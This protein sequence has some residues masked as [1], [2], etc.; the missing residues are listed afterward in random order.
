MTV[1]CVALVLTGALIASEEPADPAGD[2]PDSLQEHE[3]FALKNAG[4]ATAGERLFR[5]HG[6]LRCTSCHNI[7][8]MEKSGPNL[9]GVGDKFTRKELIREILL[10][11]A[12]IKPGFE[13]ITLVLRDGRVLSGRVERAN[14][15]LYRI[16]DVNGKQRN[17][18]ANEVVTV[19]VSNASLMP[20]GL[21][22]DL[23]LREFAD[24]IAYLS[25]LKF[26]VKKGFVAG[27]R[28][29]E[30]PRSQKPVRFRPIHPQELAFENPV[31]CGA[32]PATDADLVVVEHHASRIWRLV[33]GEGRVRKELFLDLGDQTH[34]S[35]N[36]GLTCLAFHPRYGENRRYFL[37]HEVRERGEVKTTVVERR[38]STDGLT[39]GG[40]PSRRLLEVAQPASNHNGGCLAFGPDR[41]LYV[42]F[43]DGGPQRDPPGYSQNPRILHG[44][45]LRIDVDRRDPG[46]PY[47]IPPDNPFLAQ[48]ERDPA[49]RPETWAIGFR[50]PWRFSFDP[51]TKELYVGDVGQDTFEEVCLVRRGENHGWNVREGFERFSEEYR[52]EGERYSDPLLVYRHGLGFSV[53]GGYVYRG[54]RSASFQGVYIF[55][56]YN[57]RR[58][59]GLRQHDGRVEKVVE[60]GTAPAG[61]VSFGVDHEGEIYLVTY[62]G[63]IYHLD[64]SAS[65]FPPEPS[66]AVRARP[67][68]KG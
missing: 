45:I 56:D 61:I 43:G 54:A 22:V 16:I 27:G 18:P 51:V 52:R 26:G 13:Q 25:S 39:D 40:E 64:L 12:S 33:R 60:I 5:T 37:K 8:G 36:Q 44:S 53:T 14:R 10:P 6:S 24:L 4:D 48:H 42:A 46:L 62:A 31:W 28:P 15:V 7:T 41:L 58:L 68:R 32:L 2:L 9:D 63:T 66:E 55:G 49:V 20:D 59:W 17:I 34:I 19:H 1:V 21:V 30:I 50:E 11:S 23:E 65:E 29:I 47:G 57:T 67:P 38:A 35:S 3:R